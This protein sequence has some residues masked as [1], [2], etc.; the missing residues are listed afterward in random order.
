MNLVGGPLERIQFCN[1]VPSLNKV[2][3]FYSSSILLYCFGVGSLSETK[4][5]VSV[6]CQLMMILH[7]DFKRGAILRIKL[8]AGLTPC[9]PM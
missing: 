7:C 9:L 2:F 5:F 1:S 3:L 8:L 6:V 4:E